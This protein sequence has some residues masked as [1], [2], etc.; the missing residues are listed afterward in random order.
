[1]NDREYLQA[2]EPILRFARSERFFPMDADRYLEH[3]QIFSSGPQGVLE[4]VTHREA[5]KRKRLGRLQS[6]QLYLRFVNNPWR[7]TGAWLWW[8]ILSALAILG[9]WVTAGWRTAGIAVL[10]SALAA[11]IIFML[12]SP[13]R[14]RSI[15]AIFVVVFFTTLEVLPIWFFL[16]PHAFI[17]LRLEYLVLFPVYVLV[18]LYFSLRILKFILDRIVPEGPGLLMDM[19]SRATERVAQEAYRQYAGILAQDSQPVY[20]GRVLRESDP[21][22]TRWTILQYHFFYAFNDWRMAA[23]GVNHHEG[24]W[25]M[26]AVYLREDMPYAMLLSQHRAGYMELWE[27]IDKAVDAQGRQTDH[28]VVY[29]ALGSHANYSRPAV[30]RSPSLYRAGRLQ[31][32]LYWADAIIHFIF[33]LTNPSQRARQV[34]LDELYA[35]PAGLMSRSE[36]ARLRDEEDHYIVSLPL[37]IA[38]GDGFRAGSLGARHEEGS[39]PSSSYLKRSISDRAVTRPQ[40]EEWRCIVLN[41]HPDWLEFKGRWG[42]R[43]LIESESGPPGP[44]WERAVKNRPPEVRLRWGSPLDWLNILEETGQPQQ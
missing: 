23:N 18:L 6:E 44:K 9:A 43:S 26:V 22:G 30:I 5:V 2:Y 16:R 27:N 38:S 21:A 29:V 19:L 1:M 35:R 36:L 12:A 13:I 28:P 10:A 11:L 37:E 39:I 24:D 33:L 14:L 34:A 32:F 41:H 40:R 7:D 42:V 25:E 20:Y 8:G 17:G 4:L 3:C 31:R 15:P